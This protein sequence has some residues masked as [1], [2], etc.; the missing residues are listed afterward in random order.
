MDVLSDFLRTIGSVVRV[1]GMT[2]CDARAKALS[3]DPRQAR[4]LAPAEGR[5]RV[6]SKT[7]A[8]FETG[9]GEIVF[10]LIG[11]S[12]QVRAV[13]DPPVAKLVM[14][15]ISFNVEIVGEHAFGLPEIL[16]V[17]AEQSGMPIFDR[18]V[19]EVSDGRPGW[20]I[21]AASLATTLFIDSLREQ[22][23]L[24]EN[25]DSQ[26]GWLRGVTDPEIGEAIKL[27][28]ESPAYPWTVGELADRLAVS[29]STFAARFKSVTGRPPL[30]Y[31][32]WWR[33][34]R[35]AS[36][37]KTNDGSSI[38]QVA[39]ECGYETEAAFGKAFRKLF[40]K[41]PGQTRREGATRRT[42]SPL[43]S[44]LRKRH[45]FAV[46]EQETALNLARTQALLSVKFEKMF[47]EHGLDSPMFN[48]LRILRGVGQEISL[49]EIGGRL[50]VP[51][52]NPAPLVESLIDSGRVERRSNGGFKI[53]SAGLDVLAKLDEPL[54]HLHRQQL[55]HLTA[56]ELS[57]LDRLLVKAREHA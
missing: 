57:E 43:Q 12:V 56:G 11:E 45:A 48:V 47:G 39:R 41:T 42:V 25:P 31:L 10:F 19:R 5:V 52:K 26:H 20:E 21:A 51:G 54:I 32:S 4:F 34:C 33:L 17:T 53:T 35:A 28:H 44:E 3:G 6:E 27:M 16:K 14:G 8:T 2:E 29:R 18:L 24:A 38:A 50:F 7:G 13:G 1:T 22:G 49:E 30:T 36:R 23:I 55:A 37:L 9:R 40:G 46:P 15:E